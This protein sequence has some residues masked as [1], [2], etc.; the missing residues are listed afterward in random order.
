MVGNGRVDVYGVN[1]GI[2]EQLVV[3]GVPVF[4]PELIATF[5]QLRFVAPTDGVHL[6]IGVSLVNGDEFSAKAQPDNGDANL[7]VRSH[8]VP[9]FAQTLYRYE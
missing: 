7:L 9:P 8:G 6:G 1:A 5:I 3:I 4:D 2:L